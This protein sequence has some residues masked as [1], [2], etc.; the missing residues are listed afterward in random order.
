MSPSFGE[1]AAPLRHI[2][3]IHIV[4]II[5]NNLIVNF[6]WTFTFRVEKPCDVTHL[7][8]GGTLD[9]RCHFN[10]S[11]SDKAGSSTAKRARSTGRR[12]C[13]HTKH[14]TCPYRPTRDVSLLSRHASHHADIPGSRSVALLILN[15][16]QSCEIWL[17]RFK[18]I[19]IFSLK[20]FVFSTSS[21]S[22]LGPNRAWN[23]WCCPKL[24]RIWP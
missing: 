2:L 8:F 22:T 24:R 21:V 6:R 5:S 11:Y 13:C 15:R 17:T 14:K 18:S 19:L 4:T 16:T 12:L 20:I 9:R 7:A 3:P 23:R 10:T 1:F